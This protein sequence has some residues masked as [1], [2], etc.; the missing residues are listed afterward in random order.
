MSATVKE[1]R[2][3]VRKVPGQ[4]ILYSD[5]SIRLINVRLSYPWVIRAQEG[6]NDKGEATFTYSVVALM[7]KE[8][9][10]E[11]RKMCSAAVAKFEAALSQGKKPFKYAAAKKFIKNGDATD[12]DGERL[13]GPEC[14][15]M[16]VVSAREANRP[17]MRGPNKDPETGK[18]ERLTPAEAKQRGYF[19]GGCYGDVIIRPWAQDNSY[20]KRANAGLVAIQF[21][22]HGEPF[23]E[24][25]ISEDDIDDSFEADDDDNDGGWDDDGEL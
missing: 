15:G 2:K 24:G 13:M 6:K 14:E 3:V 22:K 21:K 19:Y 1:K 17:L 8:T 23:G 9:H 18:P 12:D 10:G 25:R 5:G 20:G 11:A 16:Y 4:C 7:P